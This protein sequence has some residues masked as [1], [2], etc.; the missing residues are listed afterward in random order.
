MTATTVEGAV[1]TEVVRAPRAAPTRIPFSRIVTVELRKSFDTRSGFWL[2]A[3]IGI[4]AVIATGATILF[5]PDDELTYQSFGSAIG[6]PMAVIL[7]MIAVLSVTSEWSQRSGLTTFTLVPHRG[8]VLLAKASGTVLIGIASMIVAF[9]IGAIGNVVGSTIAGVDMVWDV[10]FTDVLT[11][12]LGNVLGM[13]IGFAL[14]VLI[15]NSPGAIVSYMVYAFV[16]PG[17]T[18]VLAANQQWFS[19]VRGWVDVNYA[20]SFLFSFDGAPTAEQW[21]YN[22]VTHL[23]WLVLPLAVGLRLLLRAEIK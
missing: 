3:S 21:A 4:L 5:A 9:G 20:E 15:R 10:T 19:D 18:E 2:M 16:L 17:L 8:R 22:G 13:M 6:F 11:I 14:G 23:L 7:P 12:V 1:Q